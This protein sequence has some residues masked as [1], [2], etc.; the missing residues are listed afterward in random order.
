[1][2][3]GACAGPALL[4]TGPHNRHYSLATYIMLRGLT[5]IVRCGNQPD[6]SP[7]VRRL[8]APTRL[9][10]GDTALMCAAASQILYSF[11]MMPHT[12]PTSYV[13]FI[14]KAGE[15]GCL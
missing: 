15:T 5:L 8:L 2:L 7:A 4:L 14:V 6:A 12:L 9:R 1:M 10:H 13:R 11:A 3:A